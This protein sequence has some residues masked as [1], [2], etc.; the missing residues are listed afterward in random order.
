MSFEGIQNQI[1]QK[2]SMAAGLQAKVRF[3]FGD[4]GVI[5]VDTTQNPPAISDDTQTDAE[6]TFACSIDTFKGI[7]D[8]TK[9]PTMAFMM[10]QLK[11]SGSKGLALKLNA[12]LED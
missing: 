9:D 7:L 2:M 1:K 3:D 6:T 12:I 10:G 5:F 11:I 4:D 8:G